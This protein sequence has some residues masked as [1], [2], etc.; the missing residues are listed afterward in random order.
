MLVQTT[1]IISSALVSSVIAYTVGLPVSKYFDSNIQMRLLIAPVIGMGIFSAAGASIFHLLSLTTINLILVVLVLSA[2]ALWLSKG[3]VDPLFSSPTSPS[4]SWLAVAFLLCL[5]PTLA[6]IPQ[7]YG[8]SAGVGSPIA[9]HAKIAIIDEIAQNGLPPGNPYYSEAGSPNTLIYYYVWYFMAASSSVITGASGWE[10]DIA[11]T[12]MTA[13]LSIFAVTWLAVARSRN[14]NAAW[15][16]LPLLLASSL[17]PI[18]RFISGKLLDT[19]MVKEESF[20]AWVIHAAWTPQHV[21]SG[22]LALIAIMAYM[23]ILYYNTGRTLRLAVL[24]GTLLASACGSSMWAGGF[25]LLLIL[26]IIGMMGVSHIV[27]TKRMLQVFISVSVIFC[28]TTLCAGVLI[29]EQAALLHTRKAVEFW[30]FPIFIGQKWF[31]DAPGFWLVRILFDFSILFVSFLVWSLSRASGETGND[32]HVDRAILVTVLA[33]LF[34]AQFLHSVIR[35]NDLGWD[36]VIPSIL[37]M[38]ALTAAL[39]SLQFGKNTLIGRLTS[40]IAFTL[41]APSILAGAQFVYSSSFQF[42]FQ[43]PE[44]EEGTAF[45]ASPAMWK[46]VRQVTLPNEAIANSPLDL[47]SVTNWPRNIS[48]AILS[49]R[50]NCATTLGLLRAY[51]AQLTPKQASDVYNFFNEVFEGNVTEDRLRVMKEKYLCKTLVVTTR[52]GLWGEPLLENNSVY[53]VVSEEKGKWRI[54]R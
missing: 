40:I 4:F 44:T 29:Y 41:L 19:W 46:A 25:S 42:R 12:G 32:A 48:W 14:A 23:R 24:T 9:D 33:P 2:A 53:K 6:I 54:Y 30:I 11:L 13:L 10:A 36:V 21:F 28:V 26:P 37:A 8:A 34:C 35:N 7:N 43:G 22:T 31:L 16:V 52:D 17:E 27:R 18:V 47:A 51:A 45:K 15:W 1:S 49:Q 20:E 5:L 3:S 38:L 50:R 39:F